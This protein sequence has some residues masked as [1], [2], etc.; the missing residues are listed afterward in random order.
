MTKVLHICGDYA[1]QSIYNNLITSI[2]NKQIDQLVYV[3]VRNEN[4][5]NKN[6]NPNLKNTIFFFKKNLQKIDRFFFKNKINKLQNDLENYL[7]NNKNGFDLI[8]AHFLFSDGGVA[9]ELYKKNKT[10]YIVAVRNT[11]I[12]FF[13][14][15]FFFLRSYGIEI[16][17]N[18]SKIIFISPAYKTT[19]FNKYI[20]H[21]KQEIIE[22]KCKIVPNGLDS[23][24]IENSHN[25]V[26]SKKEKFSF[27]YVGDFSKN[28]NLESTIK[29]LKVLKNKGYKIKFNI[30]GGGGNN[31]A[32]IIEIA[33]KENDWITIHARINDK[34][35]MLNHYRANDIFIMPS[36]Y[37]TFGV[38]YIEA[39]SQG[40][41]VIYS[42]A[43]GIDG[44]FEENTVGV[45]VNPLDVNSIINKIEW[46]IEN[47]DC[48][49]IKSEKILPNFDWEIISSTYQNLYNE[50]KNNK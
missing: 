18:S 44:F 41:P 10:P 3:P 14:K 35:L 45:S 37:E 22:K 4:Q 5:L 33:N 23:F 34:N 24:W 31:E 39:L 7:L 28:K 46:L 38:V 30:V 25:K 15:Y 9:Y 47:A 2:D 43:Q 32:K 29:A 16:L 12:N 11:D 21:S 17:E 26:F 36:I 6:V 20:P 13:F 40:L 8:H 48:I 27:L 50:V 49:S 42:K 1:N 19:L